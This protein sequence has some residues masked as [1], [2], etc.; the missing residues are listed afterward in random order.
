MPSNKS[1]ISQFFSGT[2]SIGIAQF[3]SV[4]F[5]MIGMM[6]AVRHTSTEEYGTYVLLFVAIAFL[7]EFTSFGLSM[8]IP[9]YIASNEDGYFKATLINTVL[10]FRILTILVVIL[11][12]LA[13]KPI[14]VSLFGKSLLLDLFAYLPFLFGLGSLFQLFKSILRG[15]FNFTALGIIGFASSA[16]QL[17][18]VIVLVQVF[19]FGL[20][21]LLIAKL[22]SGIFSVLVAHYAI[23]VKHNLAY[24]LALLKE[25]LRFGFP[26]QMQ[27]LFDFVS[28]RVDTVIVGSFLGTSGIASYEI[29]RKIPDAVKQLY[30]VFISVYFPISAKLYATEKKE[31]TE[32]LMNN[33]IRV[34]TFLTAFGALI[35]VLFG[36]DI[37]ILFFSEEYLASYFTFVL[38]MIGL[39]LQFLEDTLGYSLVAIGESDKPLIVNIVRAIVS[40]GGNLVLL[41]KVGYVGAAFVALASNI[42]AVPLDAF[43]RHGSK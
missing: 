5:S 19:K 9:K 8:A 20:H 39:T 35:A 12:S 29:A 13:F 3:S 34:L 32:E 38:L 24:N 37:I 10:Y 15:Q 6:I 11:L 27:F 40:L 28:S 30:P 7:I 43:F 23:R 36:K 22:I 14:F 31:K 21:G 17:T 41:P 2:L 33:S 1:I 16:V 25:M 26:L 4:V 42:A 18:S